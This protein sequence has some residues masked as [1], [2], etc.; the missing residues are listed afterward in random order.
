M[1]RAL[2]MM[3]TLAGCLPGPTFNGG[4][5]HSGPYYRGGAPKAEAAIA[6]RQAAVEQRELRAIRRAV[7]DD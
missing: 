5:V 3:L 7:E 6:R 4:P 1:I 2:V